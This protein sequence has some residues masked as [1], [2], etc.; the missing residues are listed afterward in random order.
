MRSSPPTRTRSPLRRAAAVA[1]TAG[2]AASC[3]LLAAPATA[4]LPAATATVRPGDVGGGGWFDA[5]TRGNGSSTFSTTY[6]GTGGSSGALVMVAPVN[7]DKVQMFTDQFAG[8]PLAGITGIGYS[9]FRAVAPAG[10]PTLPALNIRAD[11]DNSGTPE[12]YMVFEPYQDL[13]NAAVQTGVWQDWDAYR[14]GNAKW[15]INTGAGGCGQATPCAW[16]TIVA[17]FPVASI[18]EAASGFFGSFGFNLGSFN[19]GVYAAVDM[20]TFA[21]AA[22]SSTFD[23]EPSPTMVTTVTVGTANWA[24]GPESGVGSSSQFVT[25]P[26]GAPVGTGSHQFVLTDVAQGHVLGM[27]AYAGIPL[28]A[29]ADLRYSTYRTSGGAATSVALQ[30]P[31]RY[32]PGTGWQGRLVFEPYQN[33]ATID[34]GT[35]YNWNTLEGKW[36]ATGEPGKTNCPQSAPCDWETIRLTWPTASLNTN[37]GFLLKAGSRWVGGFD[38]NADRIV[39]STDAQTQIF[40]LEPP[41]NIPPTVT[42]P[43]NITV[44]ATSPA[45]VTVTYLAT[46]SDD[47]G[48]ASFDCSPASGTVFALGM[49]TVTCAAFDVA[50]NDASVTFTVTV[51]DTTDPTIGTV[52]NITTTATS[53]AGAT[54]TYTA[55][56]AT[57]TVDTDVDVTCQPASGSVFAPGMTLVTCTAT[58]DSGNSAT[59]TF[60]VTV[61]FDFDGFFAPV[62]GDGVLNVVKGGSTVPLKFTVTNGTG[63]YISDLSIVSSLTAREFVC[64]AGAD[65]DVIE[66]SASGGTSLRWD[67]TSNQ[68]IYN[69]KTPKTTGMCYRV[70]LT[71]TD[72]TATTADFKTK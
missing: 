7:A 56:T 16:S 15:W 21:T 32:T 31:I 69:W 30:F 53:A 50:G 19:A 68:F 44:E 29:I 33:A 47:G 42:V 10:S 60:T 62:D 41:D 2:V 37:S 12:V 34:S 63:G 38:G 71:L 5:D 1:I 46:A 8:T 25:G 43:G 6:G 67:S 40:D 48:I 66:V 36:W 59:S 23:F 35:W 9:T 18:K 52:S 72:G 45:G 26:A 39:V 11:L 13:G 22:G 17:A 27:A 51:A 57:D 49:T 65:L 70:T 24:S 3:V 20:L 4:A 58:D 28:A 54:V 14:D 55:P 61:V 64:N